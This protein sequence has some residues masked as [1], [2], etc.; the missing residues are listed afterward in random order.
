MHRLV[1]STLG[2]SSLLS[3][4]LAAWVLIA[5]F[6]FPQLPLA[7]SA[8]GVLVGAALAELYVREPRPARGV[9]ALGLLF[10]AASQFFY[11][12]L[13]WV[14]PW[15]LDSSA[16]G[17]RL[18]WA[19]MIPSLT[20]AHL[21]ILARAGARWDRA[22]TKGT[23]ASIV[24]LG[25]TLMGLMARQDIL[26][27]PPGFLIATI[28]LFGAGSVFGSLGVAFLW[29]RANPGSQDPMPRPLRWS[30]I[31]AAYVLLFLAG[32]YFGRASVPPP[33]P[34]D[35]FP[36]ALA[37]MSAAE[38]EH[39]VTQEL[40][41][42]QGVA[43][44]LDRLQADV[45]K[46]DLEIAAA[47]RREGRTHLTQGEDDRV[48]WHFV[49]FLS[50]RAA[51]LRMVAIYSGFESAPTPELKA[52]CFLTGYAAAAVVFDASLAVVTRYHDR[53]DLRAKLNEADAA[54][55][56]EPR[57]FEALYYA[58]ADERHKEL[59][60]EF[61]Q[62][63]D[64]RRL[65]WRERRLLPPDQLAWI[66]RRIKEATDR[67]HKSPFG[68]TGAFV[69]RILNQ[70]RQD[71]YSPVYK[72]QS[73]VSTM[74]GDIRISS[75][76]PLITPELIKETAPKLEPGDILIERRNWF[77]SNAFL[78][79]FWPHG[80]LYVGTPEDLK[81][82]GIADHPVVREKWAE[83][84]TPDHEGHPP[85]VIEAMSE[86]VLF[87]S[88]EHSIHCDYLA[89]FRP[90]LTKEQKAEA[91]VNGFRHQGKP[92]DFE[93]DFETTDK[94]VCTEV[95]Y[96]SY[97]DSLKFPLVTIMGRK[98]LPALEM[99][100]MFRDQLGTPQQQLDLVLF[101]DVR[102]GETKPYSAG[103]KELCE[104]VDRPRAFNE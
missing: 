55:D 99:V 21:V 42:L 46:L 91:I 81:A 68:S 76:A 64:H 9:F 45:E 59:F 41:R 12:L 77:L 83:Y 48:R 67:I 23:C 61:A 88:L 62:Y 57:M 38:L 27:D 37:G 36:N 49:T 51:L 14:P 19:T 96:R 16:A 17:W 53:P 2:F 90:R 74:I 102:Q 50:Y 58:V 44:G 20:F 26:K 69:S 13:V 75:R 8:I 92:Y 93:F 80:A 52:R 100:R 72:V 35:Q 85:A 6:G 103:I 24:L 29:Y 28:A 70:V 71:S 10:I 34:F 11:H 22:W 87:T 3:A 84:T 1:R 79:G 82:L 30:L 104:S 66:E 32:F 5:G 7:L 65:D 101:L 94:I 18:W 43:E 47:M 56:L 63:F 54:W 78:P 98:T 25:A 33:S 60:D 97:G 73:M 86:G 31:G 95:I 40:A 39:Q 4:G 15:R 89:V